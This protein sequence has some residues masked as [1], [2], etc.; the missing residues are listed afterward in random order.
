M[1]FDLN[2][3]ATGLAAP[4]AVFIIKT[5]LDFSL[6]HYFVKYLHWIPVRGLFRERPLQSRVS[7]SRSGRPQIAPALRMLRIGTVTPT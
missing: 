3:I 7:G 6:S 2:V 5:L 4:C 1:N